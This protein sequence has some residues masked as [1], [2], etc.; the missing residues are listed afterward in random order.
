MTPTDFIALLALI[1]ATATFALQVKQWLENGPKIHLSVMADAITFP[2]DDRRP[3]LGLTVTNRGNE[4]TQITHFIAFGF[5]SRWRRWRRKPFFTAIVNSPNT[6]HMLEARKY[7]IETMYYNE[8][9][10]QLRDAGELY[11]GVIATHRDLEFLMKVPAK[12]SRA[13]KAT[14]RARNGEATA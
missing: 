13:K 5:K 8:K 12:T 14:D 3:K 10:K 7:W 1:I 6:P 4:A 9:T 2:D 11:V